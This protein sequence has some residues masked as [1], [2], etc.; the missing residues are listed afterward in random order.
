MVGESL[1]DVGITLV[2]ARVARLGLVPLNPESVH[3]VK[4]R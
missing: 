3:L 4:R 2:L 1:R